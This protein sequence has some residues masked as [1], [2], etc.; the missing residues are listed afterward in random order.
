MCEMQKELGKW[1]LDIAKYIATAIILSNIFSDMQ[2]K[3]IIFFGITGIV[4]AL[5]WGLYLVKEPKDKTKKRK[6]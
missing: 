1:L 2:D 3:S 5:I 6:K 4:F